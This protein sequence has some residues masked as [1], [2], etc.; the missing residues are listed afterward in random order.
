MVDDHHY[1]HHVYHVIIVIIRRRR[2]AGL[3]E[4]RT[5]VYYKQR[6]YMMITWCDINRCAEQ[7]INLTQSVFVALVQK[8]SQFKVT[9]DEIANYARFVTEAIIYVPK[10]DR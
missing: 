7:L 3:C 1:H 4:S 9:S 2:R 8:T 6:E 5:F 10:C